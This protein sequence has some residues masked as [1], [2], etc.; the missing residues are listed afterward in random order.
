ML[1]GHGV[2]FIARCEFASDRTKIVSTERRKGSK[3]MK[4]HCVGKTFAFFAA[5]C[6]IRFVS[7]LWSAVAI[8][9]SALSGMAMG[10]EFI[11]GIRLSRV[12]QN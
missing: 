3:G 2:D 5:F 7:Q 10:A 4:S 8:S 1:W 11:A 12:E 6:E 9:N